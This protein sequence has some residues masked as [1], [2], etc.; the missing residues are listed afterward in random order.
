MAQCLRKNDHL[1][2]RVHFR[3]AKTKIHVGGK[4]SG[5]SSTMRTFQKQRECKPKNGTTSNQKESF[6]FKNSIEKSS[7]APGRKLPFPNLGVLVVG[8]VV[9]ARK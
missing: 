3:S 9:S 7:H 4:R 2:R 8:V 6:K 1:F 5:T